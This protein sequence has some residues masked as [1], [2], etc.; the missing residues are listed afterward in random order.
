MSNDV[1]ISFNKKASQVAAG[2]DILMEK[3]QDWQI[4]KQFLC[5]RINDFELLPRQVKKL[6]RYQ[7]IYNQLVNGRY[8]DQEVVHQV[9]KFFRISIQQA[10]EDMH[11]AR[12]IFLSV[13]NINKR[14]ELQLQLQINRRML[15]K[16][17]ELRDLNA[18]AALEKNRAL[19]LK[20]LPEE[21][22]NTADLFEG[23][24]IE[25]VFDPRLL[26][27][28]DVDMNAVLAAVN[29]KRNKKI[30]IDMFEDIPH[31]DVKNEEAAP[32]Q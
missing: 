27:A 26:G 32:L 2:V 11:S 4:I 9:E 12:E 23:H 30:K 8:T 7:Y 14:F 31:E 24:T 10:Y 19:L 22:E 20:E 13:V 16:A 15:N 25:A 3:T 28:P 1:M 17:E 18:Y 21:E 5:N 6:E 29:A